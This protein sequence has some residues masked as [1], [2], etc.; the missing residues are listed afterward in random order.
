MPPV[1][2]VPIDSLHLDPANVM[3]HPER[4]RATIRSSLRRFRGGRSLVLDGKNI[5]K[6]GNGTLQEAP[7]AG[8]DEVIIV[9]PKPNQLVAVRRKEWSDTE[10]TAYSIADNRTSELAEWIEPELADTLRSLQSEDFDLEAVGFTSDDV[11]DLLER[12]ANDDSGEDDQE[13]ENKGSGLALISQVTIDEP[14]AEVESGDVFNLG[15][16]VL[17]CCDV[18]SDWATWVPHLKGGSLF[19][20]YPSPFLP[21][22]TSDKAFVLVQP[23]PYLCAVM[24]DLFNAAGTLQ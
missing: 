1:E 13:P 18:L 5:V 7:D 20:P 2:V 10:A 17:L 23:D 9:D 14:K 4:N 22:A 8:F 16:H 15:P 3:G 6:A 12:L 24:I 21:L 19:C 11:D